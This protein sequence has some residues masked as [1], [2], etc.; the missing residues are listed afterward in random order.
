MQEYAMI[1]KNRRRDRWR[2]EAKGQAEN[3]HG[4]AD[5]RT[6][7]LSL[8]SR[9]GFII[10]VRSRFSSFCTSSFFLCSSSFFILLYL[11]L[12]SVPLFDTQ[13]FPFPSAP[14]LLTPFLSHERP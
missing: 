14:L 7:D 12:S 13:F 4:A 2:S 11:C 8:K 3:V 5:E 9:A 10:A 1:R 6:R